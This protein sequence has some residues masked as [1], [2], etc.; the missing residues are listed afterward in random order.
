MTVAISA[1]ALLLAD[2]DPYIR[3]VMRTFL[4]NSGFHVLAAA[5]GEEALAL[6]R[7]H[8]GA[9]ELVISDLGMPGMSG[10]ELVQ[11]LL[12][13]RPGLRV[14]YMSGCAEEGG[15][16]AQAQRVLS[17]YLAKPFTMSELSQAVQA[18]LA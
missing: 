11:H 3:R 18:M 16:T 2:D 5:S 17:L 10:Q 4:T 8:A 7:A 14:I 12:T 15:L 1:P 6:S 13:E 9:I